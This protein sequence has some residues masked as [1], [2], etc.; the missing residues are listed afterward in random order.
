[1]FDQTALEADK[2]FSMDSATRKILMDSL[3]LAINFFRVC[4]EMYTFP[5]GHPKEEEYR[6]KDN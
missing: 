5:I 3:F 6:R 2:M 4:I 1:M